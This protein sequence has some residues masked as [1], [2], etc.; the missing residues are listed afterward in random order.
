MET[1]EAEQ[2]GVLLNKCTKVLNKNHNT[3]ETN[4]S[5]TFKQDMVP[6]TL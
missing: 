1:D 2:L 6:I 4:A 3:E 5:T